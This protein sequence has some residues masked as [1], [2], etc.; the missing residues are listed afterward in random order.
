MA[1]AQPKRTSKGTPAF[2]FRTPQAVVQVQ[3]NWGEAW[4][5]ITAL[6]APKVTGRISP[7]MPTAVFEYDYGHIKREWANSFEHYNNLKNDDWFI[8]V[9][10]QTALGLVARWTGVIAENQ[11]DIDGPRNNNP[12]GTQNLV[13]YGLKHILDRNPIYEAHADQNANGVKV[14]IGKAQTFNQRRGRGQ[15]LFGNRSEFKYNDGGVLVHLFSK[16]NNEWSH[17]DIIEYLLHFFT[18]SGMTFKLSSNFLKIINGTLTEVGLSKI[19]E[20]IRQDGL[21]VFQIMEKL[22][23]RKRGMAWR[24]NVYGNNPVLYVDVLSIVEETISSG[25]FIIAGNPSPLPTYNLGNDILMSQ[26]IVR[27]TSTDKFEKIVALGLP[28]KVCGTASFIDGTWQKAWDNA[29]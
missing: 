25:N 7:G 26:A 29:I 10:H 1:P 15:K 4:H 11:L 12:Q 18:P 23:D 6:K 21:N 22:I 2:R 9:A 3:R 19:K 5:T 14:V 28:I 17:L 13:A 20:V 27:R 16:E 24:I 8:R